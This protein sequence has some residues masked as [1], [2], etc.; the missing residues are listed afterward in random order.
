MF[1]SWL[2]WPQW[3][4]AATS[5]ET[6]DYEIVEPMNWCAGSAGY[7]GKIQRVHNSFTNW[8]FATI[9]SELFNTV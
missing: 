5:Q 3:P 2:P 6:M 4:Q 9:E 7:E 1:Q 8:R